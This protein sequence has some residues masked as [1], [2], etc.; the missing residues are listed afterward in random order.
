[1]NRR[2][3]TEILIKGS[4]DIAEKM[5][6]EINEKYDV[7]IIEEPNSGL[8]MIK[9]REQAQKSLFYLGEVFVTEAK[10]QINDKLG[11]GIVSGIQ[12]ELAYWLAVVDAAYN[13]NLEETKAWEKILEQEEKNVNEETRNYQSQILKTR[14]NFE[15]M[16][17]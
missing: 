7:K 6:T 12:S 13:A 14:V 10:V 11:I 15:T 8:V 2:R 16:D 5:F 17:N 9:M 4:K 1:M 3:R